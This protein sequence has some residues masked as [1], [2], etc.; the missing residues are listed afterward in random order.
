MQQHVIFFG[1]DRQGILLKIKSIK[2]LETI[3]ILQVSKEV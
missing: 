2:K 1:K 3:P